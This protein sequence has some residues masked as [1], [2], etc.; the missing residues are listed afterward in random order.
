MTQSA[1]DTMTRCRFRF[2]GE[3]E[4]LRFRDLFADLDGLEALLQL[5]NDERPSGPGIA[6][7]G[8]ADGES[9]YA[10]S[11]DEPYFIQRLTYQSP[12]EVVVALVVLGPAVS[13]AL[14]KLVNDFTAM[15]ERYA[16]SQALVRRSQVETEA[17]NNIL[18]EL[19]AY[20]SPGPDYRT[21]DKANRRLANRSV[22]ALETLARIESI[23]RVE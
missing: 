6:V 19:R 2:F 18:S 8:I 4:P 21:G 14:Y 12:L 15:R 9:T 20:E 1:V 11:T 13:A 22:K 17:L 10:I 16:Q 3:D 7:I 23:E 5:I